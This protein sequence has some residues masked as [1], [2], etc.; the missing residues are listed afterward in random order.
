MR[1]KIILIHTPQKGWH[2]EKQIDDRSL[3][4]SEDELTL[5]LSFLNEHKFELSEMT[6]QV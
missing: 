3:L 1:Y 2:L 5:I 6:W 4:L